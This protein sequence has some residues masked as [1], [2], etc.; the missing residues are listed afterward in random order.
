MACIVPWG[1]EHGNYQRSL[2]RLMRDL[3]IEKQDSSSAKT[4]IGP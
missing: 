4:M 3:R 2:E 1:E